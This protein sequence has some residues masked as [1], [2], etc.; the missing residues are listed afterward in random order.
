MASQK[1]IAAL[2]IGSNSVMLLHVTV[3]DGGQI[4]P[5]NEF[6]AITRLAEDVGQTR[7]LSQEAIHRTLRAI[8]EI[9]GIVRKEGVE[10]IIATAT[11]ALRDVT[12]KTAFLVECQKRLNC[13]PQVLSGKEEAELIYKGTTLDFKEEHHLMLVA[14]I[15]GDSTQIAYGTEEIMVEAQSAAIGCVK[16][17]EMF[18]SKPSLFNKANVSRANYIRNELTPILDDFLAWQDD[19]DCAIIC[20]GGTANTYAAVQSR[21]EFYDRKQINNTIGNLDEAMNILRRIDKMTPVERQKVPGMEP[22]RV[23]GFPSGLQII[24][25]IM[26]HIGANNFHISTNG[27]RMGLVKHYLDHNIL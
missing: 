8:D 1:N 21:L 10:R 6:G 18:N 17:T 3:E 25:F 22:D 14:D 5:V 16:L 27:L 2:D 4:V 26:K 15:G 7:T 11:S 24:A 13:F 19:R 23:E 9:V 20:C 12:N